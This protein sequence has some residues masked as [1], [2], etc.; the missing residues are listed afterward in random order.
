VRLS[1]QWVLDT[2]ASDDAPALIRA[3]LP[4]PKPQRKARYD[5][6]GNEMRDGEDPGALPPGTERGDARRVGRESRGGGEY[7]GFDGSSH[8]PPPVWGRMQAYEFVSFFAAPPQRLEIREEAG[9]VRLGTGA[10]LRAFTPGDD[11]PTNVTDR[12]GSRALR[13][14]WLSDAFVVF[15]TDGKNV[16]A[17]D[18]YKRLKDDRLERLSVVHITGVKSLTVRSVYR[19]ATPTELEMGIDVGPPEPA[20]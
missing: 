17:Q 2:A 5:L 3:A 16:Q 20:R 13:G 10:R 14:G 1:G 19:R 7:G 6:W 9:L 12:F 11:E 15:S 18:A 4:K 8:A